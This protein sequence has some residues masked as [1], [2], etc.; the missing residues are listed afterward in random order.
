[1]RFDLMVALTQAQGASTSLVKSWYMHKAH[2]I[3]SFLVTLQ[4]V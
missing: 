2:T 1:M 3:I 4:Y